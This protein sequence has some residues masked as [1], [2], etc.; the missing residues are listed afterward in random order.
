MDFS[1][2]IIKNIFDLAAMISDSILIFSLPGLIL[3]CRILD[4]P[5]LNASW[6]LSILKLV[7]FSPLYHVCEYTAGIKWFC[8]QPHRPGTSWIYEEKARTLSSYVK[9]KDQRPELLV[10]MSNSRIKGQRWEVED[11]LKIRVHCCSALD[12][13][14]RYT[15][16]IKIGRITAS[17]RPP[18]HF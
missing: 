7:K 8:T 9:F 14:V 16:G 11:R 3:S 12:V 4:N 15:A 18:D 10:H 2:S 17:N 6:F 1:L 13:S 5:I